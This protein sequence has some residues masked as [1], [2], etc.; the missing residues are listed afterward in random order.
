MGF[1]KAD[2]SFFRHGTRMDAFTVAAMIATCAVLIF[3][4]SALI[5]IVAAG[6]SHFGEALG[7]AEVLFSLRMSVVTSSI[8]TALCVLFALP[9]AYVLTHTLLPGRRVVELLL[10]LTLSLP[11]RKSVV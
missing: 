9:C 6:V 2:K 3:I 4:G 10:E 1:S 7:S 11:D 5:A 8:S